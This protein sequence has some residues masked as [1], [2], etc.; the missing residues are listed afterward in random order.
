MIVL[1]AFRVS[2]NSMM[3]TISDRSIVIVSSFPFVL[4][5]PREGDMVLARKID[6]RKIV[7]RITKIGND[8]F[9]LEGDNKE[10]S[11]DSNTFGY[12]HRENILGKVLW[13]LFN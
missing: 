7:K 2:G 4:R 8:T 3:P 10:E 9:F 11:I 12:L 5:K 6:G 13:I 1:K